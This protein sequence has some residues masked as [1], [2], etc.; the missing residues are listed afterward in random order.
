[1]RVKELIKILEQ[2]DPE[3]LVY[4]NSLGLVF[5]TSLELDKDE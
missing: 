4:F 5:K 2:R 3:E 1:M